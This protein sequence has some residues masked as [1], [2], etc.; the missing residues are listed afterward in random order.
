MARL[1]GL[2]GLRTVLGNLKTITVPRPE[3]RGPQGSGGSG[4]SG[5]GQA[6]LFQ[7]GSYG[8]ALTIRLDEVTKD[9]SKSSVVE[10]CL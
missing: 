6:G 7:R 9:I 1:G 5:V 2:G 4:G 10:A 8:G 3:D